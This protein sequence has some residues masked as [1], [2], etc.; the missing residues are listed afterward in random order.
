MW[1]WSIRVIDDDIAAGTLIAP[2]ALSVP[3]GDSWYL[4]YKKGRAD[5]SRFSAFRGW[6]VAAA[7]ACP[8]G[9]STSESCRLSPHGDN[10]RKEA[11]IYAEHAAGTRP[12]GC[13]GQSSL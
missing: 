8:A 13:D 12:R 2:L 3:K 5:E 6:I 4:I 9:R 11:I 10:E 7:R 1:Q